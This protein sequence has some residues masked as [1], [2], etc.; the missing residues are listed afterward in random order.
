MCLECGRR[1][2]KNR[3][4]VANCT[5]V[6]HAARPT[7]TPT[8]TPRARSSPSASGSATAPDASSASSWCVTSTSAHPR[9]VRL[10]RH[11]RRPLQIQR[12][13]LQERRDHMVH[14]VHIVVV[15]QHAIRPA[16]AAA[17]CASAGAFGDRRA[18]TFG[19]G[20]DAGGV[21]SGAVS[22]MFGDFASRML[23]VNAGIVPM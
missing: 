19:S 10:H 4:L 9:R 22:G 5:T 21:C 17:A 16:N 8:S 6:S 3:A 14:R 7:R 20:G 15:Q 11:L 23:R 18:P 13:Q 2:K 1:R 12:R